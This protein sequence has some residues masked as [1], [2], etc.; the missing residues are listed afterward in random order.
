MTDSNVTA[1]A[2]V[3]HSSGL[4]SVGW[5][6]ECKLCDERGKAHFS[7]G[8]SAN[9]LNHISREHTTVVTVAGRPVARERPRP[10]VSETGTDTAQ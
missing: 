5:V 3:L 9:L 1:L 4:A 7:D 10:W 2:G 8:A 6:W